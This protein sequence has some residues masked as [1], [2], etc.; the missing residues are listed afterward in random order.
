M[1]TLYSQPGC[2]PCLMVKRQLT[3]RNLPFQIKDIREDASALEHIKTLGY[4]GTP[5]LEFG[6][7]HAGGSRLPQ[8]L[9]EFLSAATA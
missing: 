6:D 7:R 5:V 9:N 2:G 4:H 3:A 8:Q 1:F